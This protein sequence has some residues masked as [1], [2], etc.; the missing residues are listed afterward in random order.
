MIRATGVRII[1][2]IVFRHIREHLCADENWSNISFNTSI[3][4]SPFVLNTIHFFKPLKRFVSQ[5]DHSESGTTV[6]HIYRCRLKHIHSLWCM[7]H[8]LPPF[9]YYSLLVWKE[10]THPNYNDPTWEKVYHFSTTLSSSLFPSLYLLSPLSPLS[11]SLPLPSFLLSS[12]SPLYL[13]LAFF[14]KRFNCY[15]NPGSNISLRLEKFIWMDI[16]T[17]APVSWSIQV[18]QRKK[19]RCKCLWSEEENFLTFRPID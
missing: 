3:C 2:R 18:I 10:R 1:V 12:L 13:F 17:T 5:C 19:T 15:V 4:H 16:V 14:H 9:I 7:E 11:L 6:S 8:I